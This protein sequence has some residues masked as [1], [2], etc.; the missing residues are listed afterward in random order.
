MLLLVVASLLWSVSFALIDQSGID[1]NE[2]MTAKK[3]ATKQKK[4]EAA[5]VIQKHWKR[6]AD[7][8]LHA[9]RD[10]VVR[11]ASDKGVRIA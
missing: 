9:H 1:H 3:T 5:I 8:K 7:A 10:C 6:T 4:E 11:S 2:K